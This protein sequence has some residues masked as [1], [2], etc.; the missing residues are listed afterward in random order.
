ML[1]TLRTT[2]MAGLGLA[3]GLTA[4]QGTAAASISAIPAGN[5]PTCVTV[6][7]E[8]G[9][10]T[11]TGY[12]RNDCSYTMDLKIVWAHGVDGSCQTARPGATVSSKVPRGP[13]N[14][15]GASRC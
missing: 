5:A 3:V 15:D 9:L 2:L 14:F 1:V 7:Q 4:L 11:K 8:T 12:A 10:V 13:R 6:W